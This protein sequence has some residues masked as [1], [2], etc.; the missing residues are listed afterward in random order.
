MSTLGS[1][2]DEDQPGSRTL[3]TGEFPSLENQGKV[4]SAAIRPT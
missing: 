4:F 3:S 1:I 2:A